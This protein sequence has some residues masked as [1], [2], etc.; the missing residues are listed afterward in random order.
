MLVSRLCHP[1]CLKGSISIG[2]VQ[3]E[4]EEEQEGEVVETSDDEKSG[5]KNIA[6]GECARQVIR[7]R[8]TK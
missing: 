8:S 2:M 1:Q 7:G 4:N 5:C 6:R 3:V